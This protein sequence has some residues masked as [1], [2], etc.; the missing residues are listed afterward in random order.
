MISKAQFSVRKDI[1]R[2]EGVEGGFHSHPFTNV[3]CIYMIYIPHIPYI[4]ISKMY[5]ATEFSREP[6]GKSVVTGSTPHTL[7]EMSPF[8]PLGVTNYCE[9]RS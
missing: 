9:L 7:R 2:L 1:Y 8:F 4:H 6:S 3:V 5:I